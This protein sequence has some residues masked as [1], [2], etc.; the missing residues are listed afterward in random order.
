MMANVEPQPRV[1]LSKLRDIGWALWDPIG[2]LREGSAFSGKWDDD[3][4]KSFADE[5]DTYLVSA[6]NQLRQGAPRDVVAKFLAEIEETHMG[7]GCTAETRSRAEA[8][9]D[10]IIAEDG[11]W[12]MPDDFGR[13]P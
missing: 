5:Y 1:R 9:V 12:T 7:L 6:A 8:V 4:N 3:S 2:L 11:L 10:A 13:F